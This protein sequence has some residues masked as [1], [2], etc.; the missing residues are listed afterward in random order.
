MDKCV[1]CQVDDLRAS[2]VEFVDIDPVLVRTWSLWG[3]VCDPDDA[4][5]AQAWMEAVTR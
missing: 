2:G 4:A 3:C 1:A 5:A